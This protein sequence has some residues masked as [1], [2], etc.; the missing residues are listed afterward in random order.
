[1][2]TWQ[3]RSGRRRCCGG[4]EAVFVSNAIRIMLEVD[5]LIKLE[6]GSM[7]TRQAVEMRT[8]KMLR[9]YVSSGRAHCNTACCIIL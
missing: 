8:T 6:G 5:P 7:T 2:T 9:P 1:M 4:T 3:W